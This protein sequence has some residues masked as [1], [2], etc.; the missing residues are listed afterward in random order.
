MGI[1]DDLNPFKNP[2]DPISTAV[3]GAAGI[4][5]ESPFKPKGT[6]EA[7]AAATQAQSQPQTRADWARL[8]DS[9]E[10]D[11]ENEENKRRYLDFLPAME[12]WQKTQAPPVTD[13]NDQRYENM[14]GS[15]AG[16]QNALA[17]RGYNSGN[18][19]SGYGDPDRQ[20]G[21]FGQN[22]QKSI[23]DRYYADK[24]LGSQQPRISGGVV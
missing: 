7:T 16:Q 19:L 14:W 17:G 13:R 5:I 11:W 23:L 21:Y 12:E 24:S 22:N 2:I 3:L 15:I 10:I 6:A 9:G 20:A 18:Y 4:E 1:F 8:Q